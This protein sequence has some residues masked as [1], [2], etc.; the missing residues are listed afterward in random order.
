MKQG[1]KRVRTVAVLPVILTLGNCA[2]GIIAIV[3][4]F[5]ARYESA[6]W[7]ILLGMLFDG[8]DGR[9]ARLIGE[10]SN[11]G[12]QLDSLCDVIT[13][14]IAPAFLV[15]GVCKNQNIFGI[16][17]PTKFL[18]AVNIFFIICTVLRL[19]RFNVENHPDEKYHTS[20]VGLPSP[21]AG[22]LIS[23]IVIYGTTKTSLVPFLP[24]ITFILAFLMVSRINYIHFLN[25]ILGGKKTFTAFIEITAIIFMLA[26]LHEMA[27]L[28]A[29]G[30][31]V[32][33][34]PALYIGTQFKKKLHKNKS[35]L[36]NSRAA[37]LETKMEVFEEGK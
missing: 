18:I 12:A 2:S 33:S 37:L 9:V 7:F 3:N 14:G 15:L 8:F 1:R 19:A 30:I 6:A 5:D 32:V 20:F 36:R 13:F 34:G 11:F 25:K 17:E 27:I 4:I 31:Y 35:I 26:L 16:E 21:G 29:F 23:A 22:G 24:F 10:A 28:I